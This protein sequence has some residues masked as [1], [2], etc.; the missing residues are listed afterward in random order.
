MDKAWRVYSDKMKNV[1]VV[2]DQCTEL[3]QDRK[4]RWRKFQQIRSYIDRMV[5]S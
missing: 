2:Q 5:D 4:A 3:K 1:K